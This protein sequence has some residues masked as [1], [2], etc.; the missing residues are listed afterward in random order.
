MTAFTVSRV[1]QKIE[2]LRASLH[3]LDA[4]LQN[5]HTVFVTDAADADSVR[6]RSDGVTPADIASASQHASHAGAPPA[7]KGLSKKALAKLERQR[8]AKYDELEQRIVRNEKMGRALQRLSMER[9]LMGKGARKTIRKKQGAEG[10][11]AQKRQFKFKQ[12]RKK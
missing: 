10:G 2:R 12:R 9:A 3:M 8:A 7:S 6:L 4:P 11:G 5:R 1:L